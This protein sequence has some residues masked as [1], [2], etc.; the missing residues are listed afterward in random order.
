M[1]SQSLADYPLL[2]EAKDV[3]GS[4]THAGKVSSLNGKETRLTA[5]GRILRAYTT[6]I[7]P[8]NCKQ[9]LARLQ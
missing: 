4:V 5:C 8:L 6:S 9:C 3:R 1:K 7:F 2:V